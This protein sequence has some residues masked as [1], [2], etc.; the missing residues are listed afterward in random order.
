MK[1]SVIFIIIV[2]FILSIFAISFYGGAVRDDHFKEYYDYVLFTDVESIELPDMDPIK[3]QT[4]NFK[5]DQDDN[6][7]FLHV[8]AAPQKYDSEG[9]ACDAFEFIITDGNGK[10]HDEATGQDYD[11]AVIERNL[12]RFNC[13]CSVTVMVRATDGSGHSDYCTFIC[14]EGINDTE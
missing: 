14:I 3:I 8:D 5:P 1:K 4:I 2:T 11:Y 12:L 13:A 9:K 10:F 7:I 6:A